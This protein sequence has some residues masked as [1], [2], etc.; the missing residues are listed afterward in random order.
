MV[1]EW[2]TVWCYLTGHQATEDGGTIV[3]HIHSTGCVKKAS[4]RYC[5][6]R[7]NEDGLYILLQWHSELDVGKKGTHTHKTNQVYITQ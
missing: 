4:C 2:R 7:N 1:V 3:V 6:L 5:C